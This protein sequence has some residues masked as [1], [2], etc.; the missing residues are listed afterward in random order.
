[1]SADAERLAPLETMS[2]E[3]FVTFNVRDGIA[4]CLLLA[5][6]DAQRSRRWEE[7]HRTCATCRFW[8]GNGEEFRGTCDM[9][10]SGSS[11]EKFSH[12]P[13]PITRRDFGC[14]L[15]ELRAEVR[16]ERG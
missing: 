6:L 7:T 3:L 15:H 2:E 11:P 9:G 13:Y 10:V 5:E 1:M 14:T 12:H 16:K 8:G 4:A